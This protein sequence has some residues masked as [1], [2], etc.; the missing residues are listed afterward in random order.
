MESLY[1]AGPVGLSLTGNERANI[2]YSNAA[3]ADTLSG[4]MGN[5][6]Y[7]VLN[8]L[9]QVAELSGGGTDTVYVGLSYSLA[10]D[11]HVEYLY[12]TGSAGLWLTG[13]ALQNRIYGTTSAD[14]IEGGIGRDVLTGGSGA[15]VF[16]FGTLADSAPGT[17]R[18]L[19]MDFVTGQDV[20]DLSLIDADTAT[21]GHQ[22]FAF[23]DTTPTA[24]AVWMTLAGTRLLLRA[25]VTGDG[26]ADTEISLEGISSVGF[27]DLLL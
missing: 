6:T 23:A 16:V 20:I 21:A 1:A 10:A 27:A 22:S 25:D 3:F 11:S 26:I 17:N 13:N 7:Y 18:D 19:V 14:T 12:G 2:F 15:D 4:A 8:A 5:D 24:N 9:D